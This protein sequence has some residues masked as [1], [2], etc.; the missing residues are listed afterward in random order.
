VGALPEQ[1]GI[2]QSQMHIPR[3]T[4]L[5]SGLACLNSSVLPGGVSSQS[6]AEH[7]IW[8]KDILLLNIK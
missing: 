7:V 2:Y 5:S 4:T 8:E 3:K 6:Q 1:L